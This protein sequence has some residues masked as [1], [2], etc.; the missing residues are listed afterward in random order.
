MAALR[1]FVSE[2]YQDFDGVWVGTVQEYVDGRKAGYDINSFASQGEARDWAYRE[3][4][5]AQALAA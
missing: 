5:R 3:A 1:N 4:V 2:V